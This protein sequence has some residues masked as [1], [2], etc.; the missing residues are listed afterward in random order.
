MSAD[1]DR[2][3]ALLASLGLSQRAAAALLGMDQRTFRRYCDG[4]LPVPPHLCDR[5]R[6]HAQTEIRPG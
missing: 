4:S 2:L 1:T 3:R 5:L 6:S